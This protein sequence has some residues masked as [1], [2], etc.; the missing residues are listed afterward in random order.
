MRHLEA[1]GLLSRSRSGPDE[2]VTFLSNR[3]RDLLEASRWE[4][5]DRS[6][7]PDQA[8]YAGLRKRPGS[9]RSGPTWSFPGWARQ[10]DHATAATP[11]RPDPA[12]R[13][14]VRPRVS[15]RRAAGFREAEVPDLARRDAS[16]GLTAAALWRDPPAAWRPPSTETWLDLQ[17]DYEL[18]VA[19][20]TR[21]DRHR[22]AEHPHL[23]R[24]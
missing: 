3:G 18:R 11:A 22:A 17:S 10:T 1:E 19:R 12:W 4:R 13:P 24:P 5:E 15:N 20:Q 21:D 2:R 7:K 16:L 14:C 9:P 6:R 23:H 8:F